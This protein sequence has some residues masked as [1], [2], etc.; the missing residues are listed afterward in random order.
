MILKRA[1]ERN[2][3]IIGEALNQARTLEP[4]LPISHTRNIIAL[5]N[6]IVHAYDSLRPEMIWGIVINDLPILKQEVELFLETLG[7]I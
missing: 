2:I 5:R 7:K 6:R 1:I 3:A 4:N